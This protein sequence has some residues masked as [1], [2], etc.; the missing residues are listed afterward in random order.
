ML[1][2]VTFERD[3][4]DH[5]SISIYNNISHFYLDFDVRVMCPILI[6][7]ISILL[8][9]LMVQF[10]VNLTKFNGK[11]KIIKQISSNCSLI[12]QMLDLTNTFN[13]I[14]PDC[15]S[16]FLILH[17][18]TGMFSVRFNA[19]AKLKTDARV[20]YNCARR[21]VLYFNQNHLIHHKLDDNLYLV[22]LDTLC[23][24][25]PIGWSWVSWRGNP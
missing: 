21:L 23:C 19:I 6:Q 1:V 22:Q 20:Y 12:H 17:W 8:I 24:V 9:I 10:Y 7:I 15:N 11:H 4:I 5:V 13:H 16:T 2:H 14:N 3:P 18:A 25:I